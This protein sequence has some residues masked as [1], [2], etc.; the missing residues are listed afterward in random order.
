MTQADGHGLPVKWKNTVTGGKNAYL[1][2]ELF[3]NLSK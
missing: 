1:R 3:F 2:I